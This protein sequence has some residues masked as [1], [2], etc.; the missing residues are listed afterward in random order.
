[1]SNNPDRDYD[2][3]AA[4]ADG[5]KLISL[6]ETHGLKPSRIREI[7]RDNV[8][9]V[10]QRDARPVPPGLPVRTAV[11]IENSIGIW[12]TVEL[13]PEIAI[14]RIEI[15]RSSA[16]RRAIMGEIDRWLKGLRPQ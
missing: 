16:G 5:T 8:W 3:A 13:G 10:H 15:L 11:A 14:R 6:A 1:M 4:F 2:I 7:A 12:P 9:L